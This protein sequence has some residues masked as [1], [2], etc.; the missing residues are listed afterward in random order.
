MQRLPRSSLVLCD[1][2]D[3]CWH[4]RDRDMYLPVADPAERE[5][6][7]TLLDDCRGT[8]G[9][10]HVLPWCRCLMSSTTVVVVGYSPYA[11]THTHTHT[12]TRLI[13]SSA[14]TYALA[15]ARCARTERVLMSRCTLCV[16]VWGGGGCGGT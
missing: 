13:E 4:H 2:R 11:H 7:R 6:A 14:H 8:H 5:R 3:V 15:Y 9:P 1:L 16:R 12:H 10:A